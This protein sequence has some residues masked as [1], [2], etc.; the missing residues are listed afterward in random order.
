MFV[1]IL[2]GIQI[3]GCCCCL[4]GWNIALTIFQSYHDGVWLRQG[5]H[6]SLLQCCL[7]EVTWPNTL[8]MILHQVTLSRHWVDQFLLYP[9]N[10]SAK[11]GAASTISNDFG[12]SRPGIESMTSRYPERTLYLLSYRDRF[13]SL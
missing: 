10:L 4:F 8:D 6:C 7:T 12:M 3:L 2:R 9:V 13:I 1:A 11:R 5:A